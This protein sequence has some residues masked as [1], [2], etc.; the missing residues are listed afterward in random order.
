MRIYN[1]IGAKILSAVGAICITASIFMDIMYSQVVFYNSWVSEIS[2]VSYRFIGYFALNMGLTILYI[3]L[4]NCSVVLIYRAIMYIWKSASHM[5]DIVGDA[6][7]IDF[8]YMNF[9]MPCTS[10][11][12]YNNPILLRHYRVVS[13]IVTWSIILAMG[14]GV[15]QADKTRKMYLITDP[16]LEML[17]IPSAIHTVAAAIL[18]IISFTLIV[19]WVFNISFIRRGKND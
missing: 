17:C 12:D 3:S 10:I 1:F 13:S 9:L 18:L 19:I 4:I 5:S 7:E 8:Y 16:E 6:T 2:D 15:L 11:W 14:F